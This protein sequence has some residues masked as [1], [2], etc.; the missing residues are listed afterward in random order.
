MK[1]IQKWLAPLEALIIHLPIIYVA[2]ILIDYYK[3]PPY[4]IVDDLD[5]LLVPFYALV[6][7]AGYCYTI[8]YHF[9][10]FIDYN[11]KFLIGIIF[12]SVFILFLTAYTPFNTLEEFLYNIL[13]YSVSAGSYIILL[14]LLLYYSDKNKANTL[15]S[16]LKNKLTT[17]EEK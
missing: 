8:I 4:D 6:L 15:K 16:P 12:L 10:R 9:V 3:N 17:E 14:L 2:D 5:F 13:F 11:K 7:L 1:I